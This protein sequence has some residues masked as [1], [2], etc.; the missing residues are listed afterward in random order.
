MIFKLALEKLKLRAW[1][2][3]ENWWENTNL[4]Q[5]EVEGKSPKSLSKPRENI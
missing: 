1:D 4:V 3:L 2:T 5:T